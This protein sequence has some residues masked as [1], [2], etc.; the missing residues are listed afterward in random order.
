MDEDTRVITGATLVALAGGMVAFLAFTGRGRDALRHVG[1]A[2][3]D[4]S[5]TLHDIRAIVQ[6]VEGLVR[7]TQATVTDFRAAFPSTNTP[8]DPQDA[9]YGV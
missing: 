6:K 8:D 4:V 9:P 7:E 1:P 2:L 5:N 3:D